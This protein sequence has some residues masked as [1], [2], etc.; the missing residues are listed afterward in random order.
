MS[1]IQG[2][3]KGYVNYKKYPKNLKA[4]IKFAIYYS[5]KAI[6]QVNDNL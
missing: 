2:L 6:G 4:L 5:N 1:I 3:N